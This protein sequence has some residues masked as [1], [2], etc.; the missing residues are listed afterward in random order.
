MILI[1]NTEVYGWDAAV[2]G[3]RNP[4][5]S[6]AKSDSKWIFAG[7]EDEYRKFVF[8]PEDL[9]LA[10]S[11]VKAG[12]DHSKF[13]RFITVTCDITAPM[14]F[15]AQFDTYKVG[16]VRNSCSKM[17][18]LLQRPF[19]MS[20]FSFEHL[21]GYKRMVDYFRPEPDE[22]EIWYDFDYT[23]P[24]Y[25]YGVS[26]QGRARN[27]KRILSCT[28]HSDG[29]ITINI[30]GK[31]IPLHRVIAEAFIPNPDNLPEIDH[32]DGNKQNN[33]VS[34]LEW[35]SRS[36][37]QIRA[38]KTNLQPRQ[39]TTY[40]GK[41]SKEQR[42]EIKKLFDGGLSIRKIASLFNVSHTC[43]HDIVTDK[44][45]YIKHVNEFKE[46][47]IP[48]VDLLN[49]LRDSWISTDD[50]EQKDILWH[51]MIELLPESYNQRFTWLGNYAVLRNMYH[52]RKYHKLS[53][54]T[55]G[56]CKW[57]EGLPYAEELILVKSD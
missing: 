13:M 7:E 8:G 29:Y 21:T 46:V 11:L 50:P 34:N 1:E 37:N 56:I 4:L 39:L 38:I 44:Y 48:L 15:N 30:K 51:S 52:S 28:V 32:I 33:F 31:V 43:I 5:N 10:T 53:E 26:N 57:I 17:H 24:Y 14:Y 42:D 54:W 22:N 16:T 27:R 2:R 45:R 9:K 36:E 12:S 47:A 6:W 20:D 35:V 49:E 19:E 55:G 41:F 23:H 40:S 18:R 3:M 25:G